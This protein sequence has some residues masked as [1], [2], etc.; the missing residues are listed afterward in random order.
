MSR[1][2]LIAS[3]LTVGW[4][5]GR[6]TA[7]HHKQMV[8]ELTRAAVLDM[9]TTPFEVIGDT[10]RELPRVPDTAPPWAN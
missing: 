8:A 2:L 10:I 7:Y 6:W 1:L 5:L 9:M 3:A 4:V